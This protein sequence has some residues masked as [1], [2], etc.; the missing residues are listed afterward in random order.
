M[1]I[2]AIF[3]S[4][5]LGS[6][7]FSTS[8]TKSPDVTPTSPDAKTFTV[9]VENAYKTTV[10]PNPKC[11]IDFDGGKTYTIQEAPAHAAEIDAMWVYYGY[12]TQFYIYAANYSSLISATT[13][14]F[15]AGSLG[16]GNWSVRNSCILEE[17]AGMAKGDITAVKTVADLKAKIDS[18]L[19]NVSLNFKAFD[20]TSQTYARVYVFETSTH[21]RGAFIVNSNTTDSNGGRANITIKVEP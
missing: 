5:L 10:T 15:D 12:D 21:K 17:A 2:Q 1:R 9:D 8:C 6:I 18:H 19:N 4:L 11:F 16:M 3:A 13:N 14:G 7:L 20:G